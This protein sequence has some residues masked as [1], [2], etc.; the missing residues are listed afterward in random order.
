MNWSTTPPTEPGY[1]WHRNGYSSRVGELSVL[2]LR[3]HRN[4]PSVFFPLQ[5]YWVP[6]SM[7]GGEWWPERIKCPGKGGADA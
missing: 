2:L 1:Y 4:K 3:I 5:R 7:I 6:V